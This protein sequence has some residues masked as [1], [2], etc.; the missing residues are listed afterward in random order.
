LLFKRGRNFMF[1]S[2]HKI[3]STFKVYVRFFFKILIRIFIT[4]KNVV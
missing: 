4:N 2:K 3:P 1:K